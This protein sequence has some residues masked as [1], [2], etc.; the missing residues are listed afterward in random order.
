MKYFVAWDIG[1]CK[2]DLAKKNG[3][4][5]TILNRE[6]LYTAEYFETGTKGLILDKPREK[7]N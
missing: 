7:L 2:A 3:N 4:V 6:T 1:K 5:C